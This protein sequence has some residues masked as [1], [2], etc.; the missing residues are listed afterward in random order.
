MV[1]MHVENTLKATAPSPFSL[2]VQ[3]QC[4]EEQFERNAQIINLLSSFIGEQLKNS[5]LKVKLLKAVQRKRPA[6]KENSSPAGSEERTQEFN[7]S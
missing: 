2:F 7:E 3:P 6:E 4:K 5:S 1:F